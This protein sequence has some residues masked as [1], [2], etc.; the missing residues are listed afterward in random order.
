MAHRMGCSASKKA[1]ASEPAD[2]EASA[3][4]KITSFGRKALENKRAAQIRE[5]KVWTDLDAKDEVS[6]GGADS[7]LPHHLR[8][9]CRRPPFHTPVTS[10]NPTA[11]L[12]PLVPL[13]PLYHL[14][15]LPG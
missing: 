2:D 11:P 8:V 14:S 3:G 7:T 5:W 1:A 12:V 4:S 10:P 6:C 15:H 9:H 13:A